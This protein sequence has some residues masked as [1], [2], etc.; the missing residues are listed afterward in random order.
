MYRIEVGG[1]NLLADLKLANPAI[2]ICTNGEIAIGDS[3]E[4]RR[5][6][7]KGEAVYLADANFFSFSGSGTA[8]LATS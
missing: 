1:Q 4:N 6:I 8:F 5:I 2:V 7:K 3:K